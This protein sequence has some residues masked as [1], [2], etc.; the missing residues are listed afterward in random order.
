MKQIKVEI[1][2]GTTCFVMGASELQSLEEKLPEEIAGRV[3]IE[4]TTC[5]GCCKDRKYGKAPYVRIDGEIMSGAT[6]DAVVLRLKELC[7][8]E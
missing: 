6:T 8:I 1:C 3:L 7:D 4:G 5:L 2:L